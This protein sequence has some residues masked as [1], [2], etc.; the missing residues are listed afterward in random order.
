MSDLE[1]TGKTLDEAV[2][3][4]LASL[5]IRRENAVVDILEEPSQGLL[6]FIG[7]REA[8]VSVRPMY[9]PLDYLEQYIRQLLDLM[10]IEGSI[11]V[12]E[13]EEKLSAMIHGK[14]V[15]L[16]IGRRGKTL[17]DLQYLLNIIVR[18]Q[19]ADLNKM[20]VLDVENYRERR[21]R[22]LIQLARNIARKVSEEGLEQTLEPMNPAE[23]RI[24]HLALQDHEGVVT[25]STGDE[26]YRRVVVAPR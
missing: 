19:F 22:T 25:S 11:S 12:S 3:S 23:R 14:G 21:E 24:I 26:P 16:L 6:G 17:S 4:A 15:G 18:R 7:N 20:V 2:E 13:D 10:D 9:E 1:A 5:G 8:R